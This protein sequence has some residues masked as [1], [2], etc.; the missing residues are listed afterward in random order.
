[1]INWFGRV[2][3]KTMHRGAMWPI[4]GQYICPRCLR[5]YEVIWEDLAPQ[6]QAAEP[7]T[8][9]PIAMPSRVPIV[10]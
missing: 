10:Q 2:W 3:C 4:H 9:E 7:P 1:M 6:S 8:R 5:K